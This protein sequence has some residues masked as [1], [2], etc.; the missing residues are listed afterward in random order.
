MPA[1]IGSSRVLASLNNPAPRCTRLRE[2]LVQGLT[3]PEA[4]GA[5]QGRQILRE[6]PKHL[7]YRLLVVE[8]DVTPH[9]RIGRSDAGEVAEA[10]GRKL[11]HL[12]IG[13]ALEMPGGIDD[14]VGDEMGHVA[15]DR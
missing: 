12:A 5:L 4:N 11:D 1:E 15:G 9:N 13:H 7:Q 3:L 14:I 6:A 8:E 2:E 10:A